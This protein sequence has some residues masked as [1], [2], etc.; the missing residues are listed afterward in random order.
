MART[1]QSRRRWPSRLH[2]VVRV[3]GLIGL[4]A[5]WVGVRLAA[6]ENLLPPWDAD[7]PAWDNVRALADHAYS[8][9]DYNVRAVIAGDPGDLLTRVIVGLLLVGGA[10]ALFLILVELLVALRFVAGRRSAFGTNALLQV[11]LAVAVLVGVNYYSFAHYFRADTTRDRQFTLPADV[12][13]QL[14]ELKGETTIVVYQRHKTFGALSD[15]PDRYDYAAERKVVEKVKDLVDQFRE[16]GPQF[17][18]LVLDVEQ[19]DYDNQ[20]RELPE[21]LR[22]AIDKAPENSIF[23]HANDRVQ[24]LSFNDFY[25]LDKTASQEA[26]DGRGNLVLRYQGVKPFADKVLNIEE[27]KPRVAVAVTHELLTTGG[28]AEEYTLAGLKKVLEERGFDT[29]DLILKKWSRFAPPEP[30]VY[31]YDESKYERLADRVEVLTTQLALAAKQL[32]TWNKIPAQELARRKFDEEFRKEQ[33]QNW[34][35]LVEQTTKQKD[36]AVADQ[37]RLQVE[38]LAEQRRLT[39]VKAKMGRALAD[40][41]LLILPRMTLRNVTLPPF[42]IPSGVHR[43]DDAQV[44]AIKEFIK[45]GKPVL[46]CFGSVNE[47]PEDRQPPPPGPDRL[48][49]LLE[50]LGF[51]LSRQTVLFDREIGALAEYQA[52]LQGRREADL[53]SR[54]DDSDVPPLVLERAP[55]EGEPAEKALNP[56]R[57]SLR[58]TARGL[59]KGQS[60]DLRARHPRPVGFEPK[61]GKAPAVEPG[62]LLT[63]PDSW[64]EDQPFPTEKYL[65]RY[66][67]TKKRGPATVGVAAEVE[68][69]NDWYEKG[70]AP[71]EPRKVRVVALGHGSLFVGA[72]LPPA[73]EKLLLDT[74]NWLLGRD[75]EL[76]RAGRTWSQP[77]VALTAR[78]QTWWDWGAQEILPELFAFLGFVVVLVRRLR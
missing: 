78:E 71:A 18:V 47:S 7:Q 50:S 33:V 25:Q 3:L 64:S 63:D 56:I 27:K 57:E 59:G 73:K 74:C 38:S 31:T 16:F 17:K 46:A 6:L 36:L 8:S 40:C 14:R 70:E 10:L 75:D 12:Q 53:M 21:G 30:A 41:D 37:Q 20:L 42:N 1:K 49:E 11:A 13:N 22:L 43:L 68:V 60:L 26:N 24:R 15:K 52:T 58:L 61:N 69:P 23:F 29:R 65:P 45:S 48:E 39:D 62:F 76:A 44:A 19:E 5:A 54:G 51:R 2:F 66:E 4:A 55:K 34:T 77:R 72:T 9:A 35:A 28:A 32:D 67:E